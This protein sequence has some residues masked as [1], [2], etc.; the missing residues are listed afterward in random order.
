MTKPEAHPNMLFL[1]ETVQ[2]TRPFVLVESTAK[3]DDYS[4]TRTRKRKIEPNTEIKAAPQHILQKGIF[5]DFSSSSEEAQEE[6]EQEKEV[7]DQAKS[8]E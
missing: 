1:E 8:Q 2:K 5:D 3:K 6:K 4:Q 7:S